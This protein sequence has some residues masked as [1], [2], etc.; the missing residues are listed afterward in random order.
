LRQ[1]HGT[2]AAERPAKAAKAVSNSSIYRIPRIDLGP[3]A[4]QNPDGARTHEG[5][6]G[7]NLRCFQLR[8]TGIGLMVDD[9]AQDFRL[10]AAAP[11]EDVYE[12]NHALEFDPRGLLA[13]IGALGG[14]GT[15]LTR[16]IRRFG[17]FHQIPRIADALV[18][19]S[20]NS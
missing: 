8:A 14:A 12:I 10:I 13:S 18:N 17:K 16:S 7:K 2:G 20:V 19:V 5:N 4:V 6:P 15:G 3:V 9:P 11:A 1:P